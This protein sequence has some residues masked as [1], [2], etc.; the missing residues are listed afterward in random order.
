[1]IH[2]H[3]HKH[4]HASHTRAAVSD[5]TL[6]WRKRDTHNTMQAMRGVRCTRA[7]TMA[8]TI[9]SLV[10]VGTNPHN[11]QWATYVRRTQIVGTCVVCAVQIVRSVDPYWSICYMN[12][13]LHK[14]GDLSTRAKIGSSS[15]SYAS[16]WRK[17]KN[18]WCCAAPLIQLYISE[19]RTFSLSLALLSHRDMHQT[20]GHWWSVA[21]VVNLNGRMETVHSYT[22]IVLPCRGIYFIDFRQIIIII[23]QLKGR[24]GVR[25]STFHISQM[26][27]KEMCINFVA[28][29][30]WFIDN[31]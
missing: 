8:Y 26:E 17:Q 18:H 5:T 10:S 9:I 15:R 2:T 23:R 1:M 25:A 20:D 3:S 24:A 4:A 14:Y 31:L 7:R 19:K 11:I 6:R 27:M 28:L 30:I 13:L 29:R 12:A 21:D 22:L 16:R